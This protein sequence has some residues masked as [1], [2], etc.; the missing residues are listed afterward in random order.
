[1]KHERYIINEEEIALL[2][3]YEGTMSGSKDPQ[4]YDGIPAQDLTV[5]CR[6][7]DRSN[8]MFYRRY[9][10]AMEVIDLIAEH[11][12]ID[13]ENTSLWLYAP[14]VD[15]TS[16]IV[17]KIEEWFS[18][19]GDKAKLKRRIQELEQENSVLRSLIQKS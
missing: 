13:P 5:L 3:R 12:G 4:R 19:S 7:K 17:K 11:V 18:H 1:M 15:D 6:M 16:P 10:A 14:D 2:E 8:D 9:H